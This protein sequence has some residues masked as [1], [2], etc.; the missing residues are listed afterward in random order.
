VSHLVVVTG[1]A[2]FIGSHVVERFLAA[3]FGVRVLDDLSTGTTENLAG[4]D[5]EFIEGSVVDY[6]VLQEAV[7]GCDFVV[8]LAAA[9]AVGLSIED[10]VGSDRVNTGGTVCCLQA[11]R[12]AGV[13]KFVFGSSSSVYGGTAPLPAK[14]DGPVNPRS[15]YAVSKLAGEYYCKVFS[16]VFGLPTIALRLFNVFGPRQRPESPYAAAIP[17]FIDAL[18]RGQ[19]PTV[20]GDGKQTRDF[21]FVGDVAEAIFLATTKETGEFDVL[22]IAAGG[23]HSVLELLERLGEIFDVEVQPRFAPPRPGDVRDSQADTSKARRI[24]GWSAATSFEEG[25]QRT[26]EWFLSTRKEQGEATA[27]N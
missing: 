1:G 5:V 3:G 23:R 12:A 4:L 16:E 20:F 18:S 15:P 24:L 11:A 7:S 21:T 25:L 8:H 13:R 6:P 10:P 26:V 17:L 14:E 19:P 9:R 27:S 2:G 22:N